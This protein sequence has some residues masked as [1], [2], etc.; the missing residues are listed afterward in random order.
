MYRLENPARTLLAYGIPYGVAVG[1][2]DEEPIG[3]A[4][5]T[6][7]FYNQY[8][9]IDHFTGR[10]YYAGHYG[11]NNN[12]H[13]DC[14]SAG[15]M[16]FIAVYFA[17]DANANPDVLAWANSVL[18]TNASR[19]AIIIT[20]NFG[21]TATPVDWSAQG[22]AIY[23]ALK[24]N[25]NVFLMLAGHVTGQ[26]SRTDTYNGNTIRTFVS[27]YQGWT[28]GGN[29]FLR[30]ISFSPSNNVVALQTFSPWTGEY[31]TDTGSEL[32]FTYNMQIPTG[33][34]NGAP[35]SLLGTSSGLASGAT[36]S[37]TWSGLQSYTGYEWYVTVADSQG[38]AT[39]GPIWRFVTAPN[40]APVVANALVNLYGEATTNLTL[41]ASDA[42][43]DPLTFHTF[44]APTHGLLKNFVPATGA[45]SYSPARGFRGLDRFTF[46]ATDG[47]A[48]SSVATLNLNVVNPPDTNANNLPDAWETSYAVSDPNADADADGQTNYQEYL[49]GT[50]PTNAASVFRVLSTTLNPNRQPVIAWTTTG[51]T[52]YRV[53]FANA[54]T[55]PGSFT[56]VVRPITDEIDPGPDGLPSV[57]S[58]TDDFSRTGGAPTNNSRYYRIKIVQ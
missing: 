4:A 26:G 55:R 48:S 22:A 35:F 19:R 41:T 49:A 37:C 23:N 7:L 40:S 8:F 38:N 44:T 14:F 31:N 54:N 36:A 6:T 2:H 32:F 53:Q 46:S 18:R 50:N 16:D 57:Q 12:N 10:P 5:G 34:S 27:D 58:F 1:N 25:A 33:G 51:G 56:D 47:Q 24:T 20:H 45:F 52:R 28:N 21:N 42:N 11:T 30:I 39:T 9:G 3:D 17:F 15:G 13:F 29:G 43:G